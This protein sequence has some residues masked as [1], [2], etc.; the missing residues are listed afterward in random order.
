M[1]IP[2]PAPRILIVEPLKSGLAVMARRL[3]AAGYRLIACSS[4]PDAMSELHRAPIELVL[5]ELR[6]TP[7]SGIELTRA[8]RDDSSL[9]DLPVILINGRSDSNGS[10]EGLAAGADDIITK[11]FDFDVLIAKIARA[12]A[13]AAAMRELR[14]DNAALDARVVTRAIEL[15]ELRAALQAS[16]L[17]RQ[18]LSMMMRAPN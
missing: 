11:P 10:V 17:E 2:C 8:M 4:G 12:L 7:M 1:H 6:M 15:G 14:Q 3:G 16:E 18:R 13:R 5:A 9:R